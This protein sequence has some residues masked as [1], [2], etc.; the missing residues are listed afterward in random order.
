M[1][2]TPILSQDLGVYALFFGSAHALGN[3]NYFFQPG[4]V[5][6]ASNSSFAIELLP[7]PLRMAPSSITW[8]PELPTVP[9]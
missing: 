1:T 2:V 8:N 4:I 7:L 3:G 5:S 9:G 6:A